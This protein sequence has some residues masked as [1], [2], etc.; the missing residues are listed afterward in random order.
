LSRASSRNPA[1]FTLLFCACAATPSC[2]ASWNLGAA[3]PTGRPESHGGGDVSMDVGLVFD[4]RRIVRVAYARSFQMFGGAAFTA[5]GQAVIVPL[6]NVVEIQVTALHVRDDVHLRG[7]ARGYWGSGVQIGPMDHEVEEPGSTAYGGMLGATLMVSGD[8][9][10]LGPTA[11]SL[12]AGV[13]VA[14][15]DTESLGRLSFVTPMLMFGA[16]FFPPL[17]LYCWLV[18]EKCEHHLKIK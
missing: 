14:R 10:G 2:F 9:E 8:H 11:A 1:L 15:A 7:M 6:P 13:L 12:T 17:L 18:D 4:Y 5:D 3:Y 16:D